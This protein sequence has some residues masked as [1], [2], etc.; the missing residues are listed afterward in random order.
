[1][2]RVTRWNK[3]SYSYSDGED[4]RRK[5][6]KIPLR[7]SKTCARYSLKATALEHA[8]AEQKAMQDPSKRADKGGGGLGVAVCV[9]YMCV[10]LRT[11]CVLLVSWCNTRDTVDTQTTKSNNKYWDTHRSNYQTTQRLTQSILSIH[12]PSHAHTKHFSSILT[13]WISRETCT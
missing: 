5:W 3:L 13:N 2:F 12:S 8:E 7:L 6:R 9:L 4:K 10:C 1:M 11:Y